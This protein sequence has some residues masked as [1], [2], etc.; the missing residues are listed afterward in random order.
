MIALR[1][2]LATRTGALSAA[3]R[4]ST[5]LRIT[6]YATLIVILA[7]GAA[8]AQTDAPPYSQGI[9]GY[10]AMRT[11]QEKKSDREI[12]RAY[13]STIKRLPDAEKKS[14]GRSPANSI[15]GGQKQTT[16]NACCS[17]LPAT[18]VSRGNRR[19]FIV[20]TTDRRSLMSISK[21]SRGGDRRPS[22]SAQG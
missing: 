16:M 7:T 5:M 13:E 20:K 14:V 9:S 6:I 21:I 15:S 17:P 4:C 22:C 8:S 10:G 12:D 19:L 1:L 2:V 3:I 18:V 11:E